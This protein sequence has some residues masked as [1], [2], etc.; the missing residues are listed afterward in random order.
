MSLIKPGISQSVME[1]LLLARI[2]SPSLNPVLK[3]VMQ[4]IA[5]MLFSASLIASCLDWFPSIE[6]SKLFELTWKCAKLIQSNYQTAL[7]KV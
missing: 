5:T 7:L 1:A 2:D 3:W 6:R 4:L